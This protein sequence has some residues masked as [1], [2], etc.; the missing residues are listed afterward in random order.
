VIVCGH[1]RRPYEKTVAGVWFVN[2]G[3]VGKPKDGDPR[4]GWVLVDTNSRI[5]DFHRTAYD[6]ERTARAI[7]ASELPAELAAQVREAAVTGPPTRPMTIVD[8]M[9]HAGRG[10][11][12]GQAD[13]RSARRSCRATR[14]W[15]PYCGSESQTAISP[16][17][18]MRP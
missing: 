6:V 2:D 1:T 17:D 8:R 7:L 12:A 14:R 13:L 16:A 11:I 4:A 3:S 10:S 5:V 18:G 9:Q 15:C